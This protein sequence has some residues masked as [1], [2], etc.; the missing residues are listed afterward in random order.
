[1]ERALCH[2]REDAPLATLA[3]AMGKSW[4]GKTFKRN[5]ALCE[6]PYRLLLFTTLVSIIAIKTIWDQYK[7]AFEVGSHTADLKLGFL[8]LIKAHFF[9][10]HFSICKS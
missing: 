9:S 8:V 4:I 5:S 7:A 6:A 1:M 3:P 10:G 2:T